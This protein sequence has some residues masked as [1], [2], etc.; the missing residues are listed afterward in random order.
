[1]FVG[2]LSSECDFGLTGR[3]TDK[4]NDGGGKKSLKGK[5]QESSSSKSHS[6][7]ETHLEKRA[8]C[9]N[10][11]AVKQLCKFH[12]ISRLSKIQFGR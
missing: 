12:M 10:A 5:D 4:L 3:G 1:M 9:L 11:A 8:N 2:S 7:K 6:V